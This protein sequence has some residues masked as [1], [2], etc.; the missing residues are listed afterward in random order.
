MTLPVL[1]PNA[2]PVRSLKQGKNSSDKVKWPDAHREMKRHWL[3]SLN[4]QSVQRRYY[5]L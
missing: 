5:L 3:L 2:Y 1:W 4:V